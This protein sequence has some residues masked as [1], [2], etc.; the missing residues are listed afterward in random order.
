V[1]SERRA[2][3]QR[4]ALSIA[5]RLLLLGCL[6][7]A[8]VATYVAVWPVS[9]DLTQAPEFSYEYLVQY[10]PI[11][12]FFRPILQRFEELF[13]TAASSL[14]QLT[15][16]LSL[17]WIGSF[18]LYFLA[19]AIMRTLPQRWWTVLLVLAF[20]PLFQ[21]ALFL[22]PGLF[23]TDMFSYVMYG[24]IPRVYDLN[25]Y[26]YVPGY[27]P[28]NRV[29]S[30]IHP[31]W[32]YTPSIYGP[33]WLN[34]SVWLTGFVFERSA[35]D[36]TLIYRLLANVGHLVNVVLVGFLLHR[37]K[38]ARPVALLLLFAWNPLLLFEFGASGHNDVLML[39]L[40]LLCCLL[41]SYS[42]RL[43]AVVA[44]A[45]AALV[46][47]T[48]VLLL[49]LLLF[50]WASHQR[51][52]LAQLGRLV[53]GGLVFV[54]VVVAFYLP[55]YRGPETFQLIEYWSKGPMYL[56]YVPDLAALTIADQL[57][58]PDRLNQEAAWEQARTWIKWL[59]RIIFVGYFAWELFRVHRVQDLFASMA[60]VFLVFLLLV[61]TWVL[62]WYLTWSF[63]LTVPLGWERLETR[64]ATGFTLTAP[65]MMYN[66]HYWSHHM[67]P[68][69]WLVYLAP[70]L[71]LLVAPIRRLVVPRYRRGQA[72]RQPGSH[73]AAS[74]AD[75]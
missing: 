11:W 10:Q 48:P 34:L 31:V 21:L 5:G 69:L 59:T 19:F 71:L 66:H 24:F 54:A 39:S 1:T 50:H 6:G 35:V 16:M 20:T 72:T 52:R 38:P 57:L 67:A 3:E 30:W 56:N 63:V 4:S 70:L 17:F 45:A 7:S 28:N 73:L 37:L 40:L 43:L 26:I 27:F 64:L 13:P 49:P 8:L 15:L 36:Q 74:H 44:L 58:D 42:Q 61:N 32:Y 53:L 2:V 41:V 9:F 60:R 55:W 18:L 14:E 47:M 65:L 46:K 29:T 12:E 68:W 22:M 25:P 62:P 75:S 33:I 51:T 23:T